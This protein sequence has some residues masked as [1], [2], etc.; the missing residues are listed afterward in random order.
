MDLSAHVHGWK[1]KECGGN[2]GSKLIES[3]AAWKLST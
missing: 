3:E 2:S 1:C